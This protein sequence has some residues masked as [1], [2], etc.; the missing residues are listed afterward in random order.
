MQTTLV[1]TLR[2]FIL[3]ATYRVVAGA[4]GGRRPCVH[5]YGRLEDGGTFL[6]RDDRRRP[7]FYICDADSERAR[8]LGAEVPGPADRQT[9]AGEP[10]WRDGKPTGARAGRVLRRG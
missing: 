6:V 9:F 3:Q 7:H 4:G 10:V 1:T 2:G 8:S 5:L